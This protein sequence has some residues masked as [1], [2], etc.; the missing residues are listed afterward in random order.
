[1]LLEKRA[2]AFAEA[3]AELFFGFRILSFQAQRYFQAELRPLIDP[4]NAGLAERGIDLKAI[5][6]IAG[7]TSI[8]T[9]AMY[10]EANPKRLARILQEVS[11]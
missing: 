9:T 6:E 5:A 11:W 1:V 10:V 3:I 2:L 4:Y 7:H 8:R